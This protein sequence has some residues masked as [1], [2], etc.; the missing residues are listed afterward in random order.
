MMMI[1]SV[2]AI[3]WNGPGPSRKMQKRLASVHHGENG[4]A[5]QFIPWYGPKV[6]YEKR[7]PIQMFE[8]KGP[9]RIGPRVR[10]FFC[11]FDL[12]LKLFSKVDRWKNYFQIWPTHHAPFELAPSITL[13][14]PRSL[15]CKSR[16][17]ISSWQF[18]QAEICRGCYPAPIALAQVACSR[19]GCFSHLVVSPDSIM[20][21]AGRWCGRRETLRLRGGPRIWDLGIQNC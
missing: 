19:N 10:Y 7:S 6:W 3:L 8:K 9:I 18:D 13:N 2:R 15:A 16:R 1:R 21:A 17:W 4:K 11:Y 12:F 5:H 20:I 14:M